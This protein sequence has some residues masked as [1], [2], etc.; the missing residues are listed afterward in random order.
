MR[1]ASIGSIAPAATIMSSS[2][3]FLRDGSSVGVL[4][5]VTAAGV[6]GQSLSVE[7][8]DG[9]ASSLVS[10]LHHPLPAEAESVSLN[11][12]LSASLAERH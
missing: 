2:L 11:V 6:H 5:Y 8:G 9:A 12:R 10:A 4:V 1:F 7:E 3:V